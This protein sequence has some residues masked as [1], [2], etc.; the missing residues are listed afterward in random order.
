M[1]SLEDPTETAVLLAAAFLS[2]TFSP[3][4]LQIH[5]W[6][7]VKCSMVTECN[8]INIT[9]EDSNSL[10]SAQTYR[11]NASSNFSTS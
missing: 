7:H 6:F 2:H 5:L 8:M 9:Q 1:V 10:Y 3:S 4:Q 11:M